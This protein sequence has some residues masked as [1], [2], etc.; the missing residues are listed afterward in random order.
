MEKWELEGGGFGSCGEDML[1]LEEVSQRK[2]FP[3]FNALGPYE[4]SNVSI[5]I[6]QRA[7]K[8]TREVV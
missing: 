8:S 4:I 5:P 3:G 7:V 1:L 2:G 6:L